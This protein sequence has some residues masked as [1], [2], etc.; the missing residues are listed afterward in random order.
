VATSAWPLFDLRLSCRGLV[1][2]Q[3][4]E[5]DLPLLA[6]I[7]PDDYEHDPHAE[8]LPG[9]DLWQN[10]ARLCYQ[11]YWRS[12]GTWS[13]SSWCLEFAVESDGAVVGVQSLEAEQFPV[14]RTVGTGSWLIPAARGRG[15]GVAMR[16]AVLGLA[17]DHLGAL[18]AVSAARTGNA[19]SLGVSRRIG[20]ADNGVS[21]TDSADGVVEL[22]QFRLTAAGWLAAGHA[23]EVSVIGFEPCRPW[24]GPAPG[25]TADRTT[26][27][28]P[29]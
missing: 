22:V 3:V 2:R 26:A 19:A 5:G 9:L 11:S 1:L 12:V 14:L 7:Q 27:S 28:V 23:D 20:Y 17:F 8:L 4:T 6:A 13:P 18:A 29:G 24:F 10:R 25:H 21:L 15:L 16:L